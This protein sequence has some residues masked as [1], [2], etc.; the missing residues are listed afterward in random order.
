M[1]Q[2]KAVNCQCHGFFCNTRPSKNLEHGQQCQ[3]SKSNIPE[4]MYAIVLRFNEFKKNQ[5]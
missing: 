2:K 3:R 5:Q 4:E 1:P